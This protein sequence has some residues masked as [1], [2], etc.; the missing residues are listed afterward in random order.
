MPYIYTFYYRQEIL[1][2]NIHHV[3]SALNHLAETK[4]IKV[5]VKEKI[6]LLLCLLPLYMASAVFRITTFIIL[7]T[8]LNV[9]AFLPMVI[10]LI[11]N[12][13]CMQFT[14]T[15]S[16][17]RDSRC[18]GCISKS[19]VAAIAAVFIPIGIMEPFSGK[20]CI[21][22]L[23]N[24]V[25]DNTCVV[26]IMSSNWLLQSFYRSFVYH[27]NSKRACKNSSPTISSGISISCDSPRYGN[28]CNQ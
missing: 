18:D 14:K 16:E 27:H 20:M 6:F 25:Q 22:N 4:Y 7:L 5:S 26:D 2:I 13:C 9:W 8:Y 21:D 3:I 19:F 11:L 28:S 12:I 17:K 15:T 23:Q 24:S 1:S 10:S